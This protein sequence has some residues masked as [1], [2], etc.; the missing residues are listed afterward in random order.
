MHRSGKIIF[1]VFFVILL[2]ST[3]FAQKTKW[4]NLDL[5]VSTLFQQAKYPEAI[6]TAEEALKVAKKTFGSDHPNVA[7]SLN[8][9]A[10]LYF[11][12]GEYDKVGPLYKRAL[13]IDEKAFGKNHPVVARDLNNIAFL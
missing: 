2:S 13:E 1:S 8:R 5:K 9:L 12:Q 4:D 3:L 6:K 7:L 11:S 10:E